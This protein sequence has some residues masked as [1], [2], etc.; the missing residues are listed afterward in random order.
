M[1]LRDALIP[2]VSS[3]FNYA[4][5]MKSIER[6]QE[7]LDQIISIYLDSFFSSMGYRCKLRNQ[8]KSIRGERR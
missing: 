7:Y 1:S 6:R 3:A 8:E 2:A 5:S 4:S